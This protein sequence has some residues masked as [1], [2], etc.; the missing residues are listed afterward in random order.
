MNARK[1]VTLVT[2]LLA[3]AVGVGNA[4]VGV[5]GH[6]DLSFAT[7]SADCAGCHQKQ[8][9]EWRFA[10]GSDSP[11]AEYGSSHAITNT[12]PNYVYI[13]PLVNPTIQG[14]CRGCHEARDAWGVEDRMNKTPH[15]TDINVSEGTNC[16]TCHFDGKKIVGR[17]H[18]KD[19]F[20]CATCHNEDT[21]MTNLYEEWQTDYVGNGGE[22]N[23]L[24]CHMPNGNHVMYGFNSPSMLK[25]ALTISEPMLAEEVT[26]GVPFDVSYTLANTG[27]G[28]SVPE[29]LFRLLRARV[30]V[31]DDSGKEVFAHETVYYKKKTMLGEIQADTDVIKSHETKHV[32]VPNVVIAAPGTYTVA[33][34]VLQNSNRVFTVRNTVSVMGATYKT[35]VV[36]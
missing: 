19:P 27:A 36:K 5:P 2:L 24:D 9:N 4:A 12:D 29:D 18:T 20:L 31:K 23:C 33:L 10:V 25:K 28:H 16:V 30:T 32:T 34:E 14:Y 3:M 15:I 11:N 17:G 8:Y 6:K 35:I 13:L 1:V 22:K 26:A 7:K 21:G